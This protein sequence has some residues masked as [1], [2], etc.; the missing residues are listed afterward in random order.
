MEAFLNNPSNIK[1]M[2]FTISD[3]TTEKTQK[4]TS[5]TALNSSTDFTFDYL[6]NHI[7]DGDSDLDDTVNKDYTCKVQVDYYRQCHGTTTKDTSTELIK[8]APIPDGDP[9]AILSVPDQVLVD[10]EILADGSGSIA[11]EG[12]TLVN[13]TWE[14]ENEALT[15]EDG[16]KSIKLTYDEPK[17]ATVALTVEDSNGK[18]DTAMKDVKKIIKKA[19]P[20]INWSPEVTLSGPTIVMQGDSFNLRV[21]ATDHE[22]G[23]LA[24]T[25][26]KPSSLVLSGSVHNGDNTAKFL[27]SGIF[28][29]TAKATDSGGK[30]DSAS[31]QIEVCPPKP[32]AI[33]SENGDYKVGQTVILDSSN[34]KAVS[35]T[36]PIDW[37]LTNWTITPLASLTSDDI[38]TKKA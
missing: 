26:N 1:Q 10:E 31:I 8:K 17:T 20:P 27:Q 29:V 5:F 9:L 36:Y 14:V 3:G 22:D 11:P 25:L 23:P 6:P 24:P 38:Y 13:Y 33:I 12:A 32:L 34:S 16:N 37:T 35:K 28:T 30:S 19:S 2:V 21:N 4:T 15:K 18:T 7:E